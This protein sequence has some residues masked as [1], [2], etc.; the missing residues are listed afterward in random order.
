MNSRVI[1]ALA[2]SA[3]MAL[4]VTGIFYQVAVR[5][6]DDGPALVAADR[7]VVVAAKDLSIG[8]AIESQDLRIEQWPGDRVPPGAFED[9]NEVIGRVTVNRV[10]VQEPIVDRRLAPPGSGVGLSPK[11]TPGMRAMAIR[12]DDVN[13]VAGFVLPEARVDVLLTGQLPGGGPGTRLT[14]TI[15][16]K[17]RV[18]SAGEHLTPDSSG[19]PQRVPVVTL[20][21]SPEQ[22]EL[23]TLAKTHGRIQLVLRNA[24]DEVATKTKGVREPELFALGFQPILKPR[25]AKPAPPVIQRSA[26]PPRQKVEVIRGNRKSVQSFSAG[27]SRR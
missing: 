10:L 25:P 16:S 9:I 18:I 23:L 20:L 5:G 8:A 19:R 17:V 6:R 15:L 3:G 7:E 1:L 22:A 24:M 26:P 12:V 11:V 4:L 13:G 21:L 2:I 27:E 14:K